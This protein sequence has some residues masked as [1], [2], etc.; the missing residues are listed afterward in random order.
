MGKLTA[1]RLREV[2]HY[3]PLTGIFI[4]LISRPHS[5]TGSVVGCKG[6]DGAFVINVDGKLYRAHRLAWLWMTGKWPLG[7]IDHRDTN[8]AN[9][10][11]KN[12]RDVTSAQNS[13]NTKAHRD[14]KSGLKG[15]SQGHR[16]R[17]KWIS[18]ITKNGKRYCLGTFDTPELAHAAYVLASKKLHGEFG[19]TK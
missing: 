14:G 8:S 7:E 19:R 9:N 2:L 10:K 13:F 1:K 18:Q 4:R 12:L 11:W 17:K 16:D 15:V 6:L 3:N 5:P